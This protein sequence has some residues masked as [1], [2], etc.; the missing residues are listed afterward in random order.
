[1]EAWK[2]DDY[3]TASTPNMPLP[4]DMGELIVLSPNEEAINALN[5][6]YIEMF[7]AKFYTRYEGPY[8]GGETIFELM[9]R[10]TAK[11]R[12]DP[13]HQ[14]GT[15]IFN[16]DFIQNNVPEGVISLSPSNKASIAFLWKKDE[17]R[18]L[19]LGDADP[20][21]V[22]GNIRQKANFAT[23]PQKLDAVK[24]SHHGSKHST[25]MA[26]QD[27]V[28]AEQYFFTGGDETNCRPSHESI[29]RIITHSRA[30][31]VEKRTLHFNYETSIAKAYIDASEELKQSLHFDA[32][33][34]EECRYEIEI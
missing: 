29:A 1:L 24:V 12:E 19:F 3:I 11:E 9:M 5:Q 28:D 16:L 10:L 18:V 17:H 4:N 34:M 25:I 32:I 15:E 22:S 2:H 27:L 20:R 8:E 30:T 31:G 23:T 7:N 13:T 14:V 21:I 26:L 33:N 6:S